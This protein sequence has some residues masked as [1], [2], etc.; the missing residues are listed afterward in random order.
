MKKIPPIN[1]KLP[2]EMNVIFCSLQ[3]CGISWIIRILSQFHEEMFGEPIPYTKENAE[4]SKVIATRERFPLPQRWNCVYE[5][6][7]KQLVKRGYDRIVIV[8]V[9]SYKVPAN[10]W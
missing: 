7:P 5:A 8:A 6:D 9:A 1:S 10:P 2:S 3:R 4:I